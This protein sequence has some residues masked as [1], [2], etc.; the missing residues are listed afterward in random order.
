MKSHINQTD[1]PVYLICHNAG[2]DANLLVVHCIKLGPGLVTDSGQLEMEVY[3]QE[4]DALSRVETFK[5]SDIETK[6][7]S[8]SSFGKL[9]EP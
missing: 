3:Q 9:F 1:K 8:D 7:I 2:H 5:Q 4:E 6:E